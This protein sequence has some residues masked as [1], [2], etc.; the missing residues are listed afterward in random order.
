MPGN[1]TIREKLLRAFH[2]EEP[3]SLCT[4]A[5]CSMFGKKDRL[6]RRTPPQQK[7]KQQGA[8]KPGIRSMF[9]CANENSGD[10]SSTLNR[11]DV[12]AL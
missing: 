9:V 4:C 8:Q 7:T 10:I 5:D 1:S 11:P 3:A 12:V 2:L 6:R